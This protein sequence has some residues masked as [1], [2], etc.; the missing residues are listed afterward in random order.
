MRR[1]LISLGCSLVGTLLSEST[2]TVDVGLG[3]N[4]GGCGELVSS[5]GDLP[6][7]VLALPDADSHSSH[8]ILQTH[9]N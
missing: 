2:Q 7:G 9:Q 8:A 3:G 1:L 6:V 5:T 4:S